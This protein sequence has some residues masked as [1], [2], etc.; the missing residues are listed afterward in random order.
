MKLLT[1]HENGGP[2]VVRFEEIPD[3][4]PAAARW[5][6]KSKRRR[7][8]IS[9]SGC[10]KAARR[11]CGPLRVCLGSDASGVVAE[12]GEDVTNLQIGQEVVLNPGVN[13]EESEW[14]LRGQHSECPSFGILGLSRAGTFAEKVAV[15]A[16]NVYPKPKH[17]GWNEAAA[18]PLAHLTAWRMLMSRARFTPG[19]SVLIHGIGGGVALAA[20]Q[21]A[22]LAAG[23]TI[24]TSSSDEK[25]ARARRIGAQHTINYKTTPDVAQAVREL[26][27]GRGVDVIIDAVGAATWPINFDAARK[28]GR[29]VHCGVTTGKETE[30]NLQKLYWNQL[31][32]MGSTMGS[33]RIPPDAA[34]GRNLADRTGP[35][36]VPRSNG[37]EGDGADGSWEAVRQD[38]ARGGALTLGAGSNPGLKR[39]HPSGSSPSTPCAGSTCSG[40][41]EARRPSK[42]CSGGQ[43]TPRSGHSPASF[44]IRAGMASHSMT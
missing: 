6:S 5:L 30:A 1:I 39:F 22:R 29:I 12:L 34:C 18:L 44:G 43:G 40:S 16:V 3:P 26:T 37:A 41:R 35:R 7:S 21:F 17:L 25:L 42:N 33:R 23:E 11:E 32:V 27:G 13:S 15:P 24:V 36:F 28:G 8:T 2:E 20:L 14:T 38:R 4:K 19:E 10:G 31:T 9:I